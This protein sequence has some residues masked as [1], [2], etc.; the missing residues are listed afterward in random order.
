MCAWCSR[1]SEEGVGSRSGVL[2]GCKPPCGFGEL[3]PGP[4]QEQQVIPQPS[5]QPWDLTLL[6]VGTIRSELICTIPS[7]YLMEKL[8]ACGTHTHTHTHFNDQVLYAVLIA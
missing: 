1:K 7:W 2:D 5:L 4:L 3:N 6:L 8:S